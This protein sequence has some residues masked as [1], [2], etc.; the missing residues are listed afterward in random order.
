MVDMSAAFDVVDTGLLLDKMK[1]Y[2]FDRGAV[3]WMWS[4]LTYRSQGVYVEGSMSKL[5]PLEAG[6]PQG[7]I[8]GPIFYTIFTNELPEVVHEETRPSRAAGQS[9]FSTMCSGCGGMC[10]YADDS[11]YTVTAR[12]AEELTEKL[13]QKYNV[14][15]DFLTDNK[16]KVN[17]DK[18]HLLVMTT[19]QKRRFIDTSSTRIH[20][21]SSSITPSSSERLLGAE[22]HQ[23]MK[24][25]AHILKS[26]WLD[27]SQ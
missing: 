21:P 10:C 14:V 16:L 6:V 3:Q 18:T 19:R 26:P 11:T 24:W 17:D 4:Y 20:T 8:L 22:A 13:S 9:A 23:D 15:A 2:G 25:T 5:L 7:S 1:L 12:T 27:L